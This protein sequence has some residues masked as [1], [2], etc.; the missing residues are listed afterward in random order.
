MHL[1]VNDL[2]VMDFSYL[3]PKRGMVGESWIVDVI[4][5][6]ELNEESMVQD[7]GIV[8]KQ[9]KGLIDQYVDHKL[10]VP[11]EHA[12]SQITH[13]DKN[14][15]QVSFQ[16]PDERAI[17]MYCPDEAY[18]F[19]YAD[20]INMESVGAYL[21]DV[22]AIH[23]PDNVD[24]IQLLLRAE[25]ITTPFY[26]YTHGLKKH[27]GNCQRIAHGHRSKITIIEN[28]SENLAEEAYW[29]KRWAD[30]Y[31]GST[32][33][34]VTIGQLQCDYG[35]VTDATHTAFA[36]ESSQGYFEMAISHEECEVIDRDSTVECLAQYLLEEQTKRSTA[37]QIQVIA[38]E[39]VGKGAIVQTSR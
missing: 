21:K 32:E 7:F 16:R 23:L 30:I 2:T 9:L 35:D 10:L 37:E 12:Y 8:K 13:R 3:C 17:H 14:M 38:F 29:A 1:F 4:L 28:G 36:Y 33:D 25:V 11:A 31:I 18:G 22:L 19:I 39:G 20:E 6:G 26:H 27:D 15:V 24:D 5:A 34:Q